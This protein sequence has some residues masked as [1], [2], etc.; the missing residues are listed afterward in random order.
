MGCVPLQILTTTVFPSRTRPC[1]LKIKTQKLHEQ[2]RYSSGLTQAIS[3]NLTTVATLDAS[4]ER[5][6]GLMMRAGYFDPLENQPYAA[7]PAEAVGTNA[8]HQLAMESALQG[9][10]LL[11]NEK[12]GVFVSCQSVLFV[13]RPLS[14]D[15]GH[16][17]KS[18]SHEEEL[19]QT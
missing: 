2:L 16:S 11:Q 12:D 1:E 14:L 7:I 18:S 10:V 6:F 4:I 13:P 19:S 15:S 8:S 3:Q 5:S 9:M 17:Y